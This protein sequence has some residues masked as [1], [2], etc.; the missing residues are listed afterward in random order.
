MAILAVAA[1][2]L[3]VGAAAA[4]AA[5]VATNAD[6]AAPLHA[7]YAD[8]KGE[9]ADNQFKRPL[10]MSSY[11]GSV[12]VTGEIF[13]LIDSPFAVAS[14]GLDKASQWC[15]ILILHLNIKYCRPG[16]D[17]QGAVLQVSIGKKYDQTMEQAYRVVFAFRMA[18]RTENYLQVKLSA[19]EGPLGTSDYHIVL[20]AAPEE[21]QTFIR[22]SYS[23]SYGMVGW[24]AMQ[25]YLGTV[26]RG[27]VGFT[28][29]GNE[30]DGRPRYIGGM[31]GVV[32]R[33]TMRYY[34]AVDAFIGALSG[35]PAARLEKSLNDWFAGI[36]RFPRQLHEMER[37]AYLDMKHREYA[38]QQAGVS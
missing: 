22:M 32:E 9:L 4:Q 10:H 30:P 12:G 29:V 13:A 34:L 5:D 21:G 16:L 17:S 27:K 24:L 33:N 35:P 2:L 6:P 15:E 31:R 14:E 3:F 7:R 26:G 36:E 18:A 23:Y 38:R 20:E 1:A 11:E 8:L 28:V 37:E 19:D 25:A